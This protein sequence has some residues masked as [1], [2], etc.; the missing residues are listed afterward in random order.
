[1]SLHVSGFWMASHD[2]RAWAGDETRRGAKSGFILRLYT[3]L[4]SY[5]P[6]C[7][8]VV[9]GIPRQIHYLCWLDASKIRTCGSDRS[10]SHLGA[11]L[12]QW[13]APFLYFGKST[14]MCFS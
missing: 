10:A 1:M 14:C 6:F 12:L 4:P 13:G 9:C 3:Y 5:L 8:G 2:C 7:L 11:C